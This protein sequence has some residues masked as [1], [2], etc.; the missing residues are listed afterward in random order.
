MREIIAL[1]VELDTAAIGTYSRL[2][3]A[4][5][6]PEISRLFTQM[7][8]EEQAH[9]EWWS[10][11]LDAWD[12]GL[13]PPLPDE[14]DLYRRLQELS[15]DVHAAV[16]DDCSDLST[17]D[18]LAAA[19]HLEF[20]MLDP[21]FGELI[22]LVRPSA[23]MDAGEAYRRHIMRLVSVIETRHSRGDV[24]RF[25]ARA[26]A[27]AL[28]DQ[29]R[30]QE[31]ATQDALTGLYNRRGF[32]GYVSQWSS[33]ATRYG[34]P[35]SVVIVDVDHFKSI[36][37]SFGH[38]AGDDALRL[39]SDGLRK[40]VRTSDLVGRYGGDEFAILA[41]ETGAEELEQLMQRV[42]ESIRAVNLELGDER[43]V[44][45]TVSV[46]GSYVSDGVAATPEQLLAA[47]DKSLYEAKAAGRDQA[48][49]IRNAVEI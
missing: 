40:A 25:L 30:L 14:D 11:L 37:D 44:H 48:G 49:P 38:P 15:A 9:V 35:V 10:D 26:L 4:C 39:V 21:G 8:T 31:L 7:G 47:A 16:P 33:W 1:C 29:Q 28:R 20:F 12:E 45:L 23:Q 24:S 6:E 18:M 27:R 5:T 43:L 46:G 22:R 13:V 17:D 3:E 32:Y 36:N 42:L 41:P 2:S 19:A 34:R